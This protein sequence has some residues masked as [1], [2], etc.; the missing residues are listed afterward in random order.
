MCACVWRAGKR[1]GHL[2]IAGD[3][4]KWAKVFIRFCFPPSVRAAYIML[5]ILSRSNSTSRSFLFFACSSV[6]IQAHRVFILPEGSRRRLPSL[7]VAGHTVLLFFFFFFFLISCCWHWP[8]LPA[9][10]FWVNCCSFPRY[11]LLLTVAIRH[12]LSHPRMH[13]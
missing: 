10:S 8:F 7:T 2:F 13:M 5:A 9:S 4:M 1:L 3:V 12:L 6:L 11:T